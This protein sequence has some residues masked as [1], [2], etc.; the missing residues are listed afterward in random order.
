MTDGSASDTPTRRLLSRHLVGCGVELGPGHAPF[1]LLEPGASVR[2]VDRWEPSENQALFPEIPDATFTRPDIVADLNT[3]RLRALPDESQDFV[4]CSHVI[5]HVAE[6]LGL[7]AEVHRVL[8]PGGVALIL[9]P[10]RHRTFD[11]NRQPTSL[12]HVVAEYEAGVTE[13]DDAHVAEFVEGTGGS[14]GSTDA[15]RSQSIDLHRRRSIHV[16]CWDDEEFVPLLDYGIRHLGQR[17]EF[18]D[19]VIA[20]DDGP[21]GMEFG[22]VL[23]RCAVDATPTVLAVRL[24]SQWNLWRSSRLSLARA[25]GDRDDYERLLHEESDELARC[26]ARLDRI[27]RRLPV[28]AYRFATRILRR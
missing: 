25:V 13:V 8:R 12:D 26:R 14:L 5:E 11:K 7:L 21:A 1:P 3:D 15:E 19:G 28:R 23:R 17:W 9:L 27:E 6:P 16:H 10:D 24:D 20:A 18:V 22:F 4:I 2:Y